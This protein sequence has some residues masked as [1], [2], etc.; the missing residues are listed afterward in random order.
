MAK[1][2]FFTLYFSTSSLPITLKLL[3]DFW[4]RLVSQAMKELEKEIKLI[5]RNRGEVKV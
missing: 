4:H 1:Y 3:T 5:Y 2:Y